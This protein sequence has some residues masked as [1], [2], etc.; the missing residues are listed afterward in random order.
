[1][2]GSRTAAPWPHKGQVLR[3]HAGLEDVDDLIADLE[4]GLERLNAQ[5]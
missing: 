2:S 4:K 1:L 5:A 3:I